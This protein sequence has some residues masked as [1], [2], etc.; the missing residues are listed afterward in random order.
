MSEANKQVVNFP[1]PLTW[2]R[3][4]LKLKR[5]F[6]PW[7]LNAFQYLSTVTDLG[8]HWKPTFISSLRNVSVISLFKY[9]KWLTPEMLKHESEIM[10]NP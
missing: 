9:C 8:I 5:G 6:M 3:F 1:F 10:E 2:A 7:D 4:F